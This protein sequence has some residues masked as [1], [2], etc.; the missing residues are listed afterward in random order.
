MPEPGRKN[1][2]MVEDDPEIGRYF[3]NGLEAHGFRVHV[4][5]HG[6]KALTYA[7]DH[8]PDLA[9]LDLNLPDMIG[10]DVCLELR[11]L[12]R[13]WIIPIVMLTGAARPTD[14]L[15]AFASGSDVYLIKPIDVAELVRTV[16]D[17]LSDNSQ[18][19]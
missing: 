11:R 14:K 12:C 16:R 17:L 5:T 15:R 3:K 4:E 8:P 9:V 10:H 1:I 18:A 7:A 19:A 6:A 2:L 13:P